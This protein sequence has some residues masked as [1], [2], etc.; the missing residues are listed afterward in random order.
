MCQ[1]C[2]CDFRDQCSIV[3]YITS[4]GFCCEKCFLYDE[5][6]TCLLSRIGSKRPEEEKDLGELC[7]IST[8]I[9]GG[10]LKV[11]IEQKGKR[12]PILIDLQKHL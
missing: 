6:H 10:M 12:I 9:E 4:P 2:N 7:P 3:G 11:V 8:K 1:N 5:K